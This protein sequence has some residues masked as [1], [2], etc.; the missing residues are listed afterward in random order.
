MTKCSIVEDPS[1]FPGPCCPCV[2]AGLHVAKLVLLTA[3][4]QN[5]SPML[6]ARELCTTSRQDPGRSNPLFAHAMP[7]EYDRTRS[8][9][10]EKCMAFFCTD[11]G[12]QENLVAG[13]TRTQHT[14]PTSTFVLHPNDMNH[15]PFPQ[16]P[17]SVSYMQTDATVFPIRRLPN[18]CLLMSAYRVCC[19]SCGREEMWM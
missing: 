16:L 6:G 19:L 7:R 3:T 10:T 15:L 2:H 18:V 9:W 4:L 5:L 13:L 17:T 11:M 14:Q 8:C 1:T 12:T